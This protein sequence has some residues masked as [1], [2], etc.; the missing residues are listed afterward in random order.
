MTSIDALLISCIN[1]KII[2][3]L[4]IGAVLL[5]IHG[6]SI[7]MQKGYSAIFMPYCASIIIMKVYFLV[8]DGFSSQEITLNGTIY[9]SLLYYQYFLYKCAIL[10]YMVRQKKVDSLLFIYAISN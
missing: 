9:T 8:Q 5:L 6:I 2:D 7:F 4:S 10:L 3:M 1:N